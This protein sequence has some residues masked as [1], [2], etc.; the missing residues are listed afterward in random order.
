VQDKVCLS[1][2]VMMLSRDGCHLHGV[3]K[4][5]GSFYYVYE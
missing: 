2:V 5:S 3:M 4:L 1:P